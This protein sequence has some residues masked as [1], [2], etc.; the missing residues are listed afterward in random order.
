L[1]AR[2]LVIKLRAADR[3]AESSVDVADVDVALPPRAC[4]GGGGGINQGP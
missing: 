4:R 2:D 1:L 3:P